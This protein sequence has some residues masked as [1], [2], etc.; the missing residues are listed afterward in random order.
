MA[1]H[2]DELLKQG[3]ALRKPLNLV[4]RVRKEPQIVEYVRKTMEERDKV[5]AVSRKYDAQMRKISALVQGDDHRFKDDGEL[6]YCLDQ[7]GALSSA[8]S[9]VPAGESW[10]ANLDNEDLL[11][12]LPDCHDWWELT[13]SR[14]LWELKEHF[15]SVH[16][17]AASMQHFAEMALGRIHDIEYWHPA[18]I[19]KF[20][21]GYEP[22]TRSE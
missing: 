1:D 21:K 10:V 13:V 17:A 4:D 5:L 12:N 19:L 3:H 9:R 8:A 14:K 22:E 7:Y 20:R 15:G 2:L 18:P 6:R 16:G 11:R